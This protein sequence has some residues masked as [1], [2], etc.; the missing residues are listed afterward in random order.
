MKQ[1][2][3][4]RN[5]LPKVLWIDNNPVIQQAIEMLVQANDI[6][7]DLTLVDNNDDA[8]RVLKDRRRRPDLLVQNV[9]RPEGRCLEGH[10]AAKDGSRSGIAFHQFV[11]QY[12]P[13]LPCLFFTMDARKRD[14]GA[15][16]VRMPRCQL[17]SKA[18]GPG[19]LM[20][21]VN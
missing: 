5:R 3:N 21:A 19:G 2:P 12:R 14:V 10:P 1:S 20:R 15:A 4:K 17:V 9:W 6:P 13:L 7:V 11:R 8:L 18:A 16:V